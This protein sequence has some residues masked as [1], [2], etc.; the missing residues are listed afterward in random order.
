MFALTVADHLRLET[1]Q[2]G[3]NYTVHA[4]E[5]E[6]LAGRAF[7]ARIVTA[8][9]LALALA[10]SIANLVV[11]MRAEQIGAVAASALALIVF[12]LHSVFGLEARINA[13][14]AFAHRVWLV[15]QRFRALVAEIDEGLVDRAAQLQ[16]RDELLHEL[17]EVY[18]HGFGVE[19]RGHEGVRLPPLQTERAA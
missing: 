17:H 15:A 7:T 1:E 12:A 18:G 10:A 19:Q 6:R 16:R 4:R 8:A 13:H 5:A 11:P 9:A 14:R 3:R 2:T